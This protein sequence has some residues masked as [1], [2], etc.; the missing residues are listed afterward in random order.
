MT[1]WVSSFLALAVTAGDILVAHAAGYV[2][3]IFGISPPLGQ[4]DFLD[5]AAIVVSKVNLVSVSL[6]VDAPVSVIR[7]LGCGW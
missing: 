7:P 3:S 4:F 1:L 2:L 6:D 5:R